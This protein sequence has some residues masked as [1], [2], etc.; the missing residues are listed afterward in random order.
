[1]KKE[2]YK[3]AHIADL[4]LGA[5]PKGIRQRKLDI[6]N[7]YDYLV[8]MSL[9]MGCRDVLLCGDTF[10][11]KLVDWET[12]AYFEHILWIGSYKPD[13][14]II[15]PGNHD[16]VKEW[17]W[18]T[19][20]AFI[21]PKDHCVYSHNPTAGVDIYSAN[22]DTIANT[23]KVLDGYKKVVNKKNFNILM[24]HQA[25]EGQIHQD[26]NKNFISKGYLD[27]L[28]EYFDYVALGHI[29][30]SYIVDRFAFNPGSP[31]YLTVS[32]WGNKSGMFVVTVYDDKTFDYEFVESPKRDN[33]KIKINSDELLDKKDILWY[34]NSHDIKENSML[35]IEFS[36]SREITPKLLK[37]IESEVE[38][39]YKLVLFKTRNYTKRHQIDK[40]TESVDIFAKV[41]QEDTS[42]AKQI[43]ETKSVDIND[44]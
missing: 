10:H 8:K 24:L 22:W 11:T 4:H 29:H 1:M 16:D 18:Y 27:S 3:F 23:T 34:I 32:E 41:F 13:N 30:H 14:V 21:N 43:L 28:K 37:E 36:G 26:E 31:E 38:S 44:L 7:A 25:I 42:I 12:I 19:K 2:I 6:F 40:K 20:Y 33:L 5:R 15:I 17:Q 9:S 35:Y 39:N